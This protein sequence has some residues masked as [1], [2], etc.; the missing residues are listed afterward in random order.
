MRRIAFAAVAACAF[1]WTVTAGAADWPVP[2]GT[3][4]VASSPTTGGGYPVP[5][6][7]TA[8]VPGTCR[9][10]RYNS[11]HSE[12]WIAVKP[13]TE[14]LVGASK[15]FFEKYSTFYD[16]H[17]GAYTILG[18]TP[19]GNVQVPGYDCVSTGS[20]GELNQ[21]MPP[22]WMNNT[23]PNVD[24][25][26]QGRAYQATLP[27]NPFWVNLH[28]NGAIGVVYSDDLGRSWK[29]GNGGKYL[30]LLPNSSSLSF[31]DVVDKQWIAVNHVATSKYRDHVYVMFAVFNGVNEVE[32]FFSKSVD[33]GK[34]FSKAVRITPPSV[35]GPANTYVYPSIDAA[36]NLFASVA[37]FPAKG[38]SDAELWVARSTDD[39]STFT[40]FDT[41]QK[42]HGTPGPDLPNTT[43]RDGILENFAA[44]PTYPDHLYLTY[45]D[46]DGTQMDVKFTQSTTGGM[47]WSEPV[48]VNDAA[49]SSTT[50]QFQPSVA[51][52]PGGAVAVAFYD[53][54]APCPNDQSILP[55]DIG[56]SNWCIDVSLQAYKD[57]GG[58]AA[59]IGPN[60]R[61]SQFT[62]DPEQPGQTIDGLDQMACASHHNPCLVR[63]F[64]GDYF[65]LAIS[66]ANI[67]TLSV[68]THYPAPAVT[69]DGGGPVYYQQ[70]VL[71]TVPRTT[72]GAGF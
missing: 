46:W 16:F 55:D 68:S 14:D 58:G 33:H 60:V 28:P 6:G 15:F 23:D 24:F 35:L 27:F 13:G 9:L 44:S 67:Y 37:S 72:F 52:G 45:E 42:A 48:V 19:A 49:N 2:V 12:S 51:A 31:G 43:F 69:A 7:A 64:I 5:P 50:D 26:T 17:L 29:V 66:D 20:D 71:G 1:A 40:W 3:N 54:R 38:S 70:Q 63:A 30:S 18:G 25:D 41:G 53:R 57:G 32:I 36:G 56:K 10:G 21:D 61:V 8:P 34:T 65:G 39:G 11:N 59:T 62:W 47:S 22:S 4:Q